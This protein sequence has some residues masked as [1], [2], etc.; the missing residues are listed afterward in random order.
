M[1]NLLIVDDERDLV[2]QMAALLQRA[3]HRVTTALDGTEAVKAL[4]LEGADSDNLPDAVILDIMMPQINGYKV[5]ARMKDDPRTRAIPLI[6]LTGYTD[7]KD[8]FDRFPNVAAFVP[9][10][11]ENRDLLNTIAD[12]LHSRRAK[13]DA[14]APSQN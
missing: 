11:F 4:G 7:L 14:A 3:G 10:P 1:A 13:P 6:M 5:C 2:E 9:K 8:V 12:I